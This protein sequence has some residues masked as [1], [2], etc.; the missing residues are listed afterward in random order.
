MGRISTEN[1]M[2]GNPEVMTEVRR[3]PRHVVGL[4]VATLLHAKPPI[5]PTNDTI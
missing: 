1:S 3:Y 2:G 4:K 5:D